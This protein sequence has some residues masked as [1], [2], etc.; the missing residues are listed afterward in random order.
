MAQPYN[1]PAASYLGN[2]TTAIASGFTV[3][4]LNSV[5]LTKTLEINFMFDVTTTTNINWAKT[6]AAGI[7]RLPSMLRPVKDV[8]FHCPVSLG[9][10]DKYISTMRLRTDG[11]II[12]VNGVHNCGLPITFYLSECN[13]SVYKS[14]N[15]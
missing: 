8:I 3:E 12:P 10:F 14:Y 11:R 4:G 2:F 13:L 9:N 15:A 7:C 1:T 5:L 6:Q